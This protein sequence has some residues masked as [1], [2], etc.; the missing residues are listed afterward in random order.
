MGRRQD[1]YTEHRSKDNDR[2]RDKKALEKE[3]KK[4][5]WLMQQSGDRRPRDSFDDEESSFNDLRRGGYGMQKSRSIQE[6]NRNGGK[7]V[8]LADDDDSVDSSDQD[9][10]TN[11]NNP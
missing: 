6:I 2:K 5:S 8:D 9:E 4:Y 10:E 11:I 1:N 3:E 7:R